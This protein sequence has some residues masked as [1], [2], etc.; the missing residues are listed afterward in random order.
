MKDNKEQNDKKDAK[1]EGKNEKKHKKEE[2]VRKK[3]II[4]IQ[5]YSRR[6]I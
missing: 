4:L 6:R 3:Y 2:L 1:K 5:I